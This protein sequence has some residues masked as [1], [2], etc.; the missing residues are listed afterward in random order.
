MYEIKN[1][2]VGPIQLAVKSFSGLTEDR[3]GLTVL[4][5]PSRNVF[6]V[7]EERIVPEYLNRSVNEGLLACRL[8]TKKE[9]KGLYDSTNPRMR[10]IPGHK[11][12]AVSEEK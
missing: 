12:S 2:T 7:E 10:Y 1:K 3:V 4:N 9:F 5:I 8:V 6:F 11:K